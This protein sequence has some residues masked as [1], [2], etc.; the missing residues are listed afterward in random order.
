M[1]K[2]V[3]LTGLG[4]LTG[5]GL[6]AWFSRPKSLAGLLPMMSLPK[7]PKFVNKLSDE[8]WISIQQVAGRI[9][10]D[11]YQLAE[12]INFESNGFN[13]KAVNPYSGASG[14]IQFMTFTAAELGTSVEA[15]RQMSALEQMPLV[16]RY[17]RMK[18]GDRPLDTFQAL[19][20]CIFYPKYMYVAPNTPFPANVQAANP[21]ITTPQDY[22]NKVL[23]KS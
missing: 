16:E 23:A 9:G 1:N 13:P 15:I 5:L 11:P 7:S 21:G 10:A 2:G 12:V 18:V 4:F 17:F 19:T 6:V 22:M 20:M 3:L 8:L 14:L